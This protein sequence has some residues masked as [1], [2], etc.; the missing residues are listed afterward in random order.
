MLASCVGNPLLLEQA[1]AG[2]RAGSPVGPARPGPLGQLVDRFAGLPAP[3]LAV[4]KAASVAGVRFQP[5]LV[6]AVAE[7]EASAVAAALGVLMRA[8]LARPAAEGQVEFAHPLFAQALCEEVGPPERSRMHA[9][10]MRA[11]LAA[12]ADPAQAAAHAVSGHLVGDP[13][14]VECLEAAGRAAARAGA[15][16][17]AVR[18]LASAVALAGGKARSELLL[19]LAEAQLGAGLYGSAEATCGRLLE[20]SP[21]PT[22]RADALVLLARAANVTGKL[23]ESCR[24]YRTA[25]EAAEGT[26]RLVRV[27]AE[28]VGACS[29]IEGPARVGT[30]TD[31][32]RAL[33]EGLP[34]QQRLEADL[35]WGAAASLAGDPVGAETVKAALGPRNVRSV[36]ES[37][38]PSAACSMLARAFDT[39]LYMECF[40][41][42]DELFAVAWEV[43]ERQGALTTMSMLAVIGAA[44][45]WWRGRLRPALELLG[46]LAEMSSGLGVVPPQLDQLVRA[47]IATETG[48]FGTAISLADS[49]EHRL[50][51]DPSTES[52]W[53]LVQL[54]RIRGEL[55]LDAGRDLEAV[56]I[57]VKMRELAQRT[58]ALQPLW[59]PWADTAM[60]AFL[61]AKMLDN[62]RALVDHLEQVSSGWACRWP[63]SVAASGRAGVAEATGD[64]AEAE[65]Q[66]LRAVELLE[67]I[68]LPPHRA[69]ALISYGRFLRRSG[70]AVLARPPLARA[71]EECEACG[72]MRLASQA[73]AELE[74]SGGRRRRASSVQ[75]SPQELRVAQLAAQGATNAEI[76][77]PL[78]ISAKT[79]EH[80]LTSVYAKLGVRSRR[81]L[82]EH[83]DLAGERLGKAQQE[84]AAS[85][86]AEAPSLRRP[87]RSRNPQPLA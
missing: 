71:L 24:R 19:L 5:S 84:G 52:P 13:Q 20:R 33:S 75:L 85:P 72:A 46:S 43:A 18:S 4:A 48:D 41:E 69:R 28:A 81:E 61:R 8:G 79:V 53:D 73:R 65:R 31:R 2:L 6:A 27:L 7:T 32:L 15:S 36:M 12:G 3:V 9:L 62:C 38:A 59:T 54:L 42:A 47:M 68:D 50:L 23:G 66:H 45:F 86:A 70:R 51:S 40:E 76:A 44:G 82:R 10:A 60:E 49:A 29:R 55:A 30:I 78:F 39:L 35:A 63:R 1:G 11:L 64:L 22:A 67:G 77:S 80:H 58:G 16:D 74:A 83:F 14:A 21:D 17:S 25:V 57:A 34:P 26:D 56:E 37:A 87:G